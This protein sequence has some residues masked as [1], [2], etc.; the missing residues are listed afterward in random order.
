MISKLSP[1]TK[2]SFASPSIKPVLQSSNVVWS[3]Y[4]TIP[5]LYLSDC[6]F[7]KSLPPKFEHPVIKIYKKY[8][9]H[10]I[11]SIDIISADKINFFEFIS[12]SSQKLSIKFSIIKNTL[13]IKYSNYIK[14]HS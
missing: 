2:P 13:F 11:K 14:I 6:C 4:C 5:I 9:M 10:F 12:C 3:A 7:F 8:T 1:D